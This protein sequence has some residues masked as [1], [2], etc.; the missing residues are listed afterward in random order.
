MKT[1]VFLLEEP[2]AEEMLKGVLPRILPED[3]FVQ[4]ITFDGKTDLDNNVELKIRAWRTPNTYFALMRD[5]HSGDCIVIKAGLVEKCQRAGRA[6]SLVRI[7]CHELES[8]YLGDLA[9]VEQ[10]LQERGVGRKQGKA[11]YRNPDALANAADELGKL[12]SMKYQKA[13]GS[14]AIGP[15]LTVDNSNRSHSFNLLVSGIKSLL[16]LGQ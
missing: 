13:S 16:G 15:Y 5:K 3:V 2:S 8:Y 14:R 11:K 6:D 4:Y 1:L 7:A 9:A 12:T 10:G